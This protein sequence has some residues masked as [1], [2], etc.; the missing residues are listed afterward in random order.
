MPVEKAS[1]P[2]KKT[3]VKGTG[4]KKG[5]AKS[6]TVA[7]LKAA[8]RERGLK[9]SGKKA[10]LMERLAEAKANGTDGAEAANANPKTKSKTLARTPTHAQTSPKPKKPKAKAGP[11]KKS[12][13]KSK[14]KKTSEPEFTLQDMQDAFKLLDKDSDGILSLPDLALSFA[15][16]K[17]NVD[18]TL[19]EKMIK[20]AD[21]RGDR[22]GRVGIDDFIGLMLESGFM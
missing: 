18:H 11:K 8:L 12:P 16:L 2:T 22:D 15:S 9:V 5:K 3:L 14:E 19:L 1:K 20:F 10:E 7:E 13:T 17:K 4:S 6:M 21:R